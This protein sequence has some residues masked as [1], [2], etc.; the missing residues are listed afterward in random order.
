MAQLIA[1]EV[2][3]RLKGQDFSRKARDE[4][5]LLELLHGSFVNRG[6]FIERLRSL[7]PV[8]GAVHRA[9]RLPLL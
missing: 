7:G 5:F 8:P 6:H 3:A 2:Y 4:D 1:K 9:G